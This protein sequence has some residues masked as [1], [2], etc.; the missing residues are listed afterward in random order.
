MNGRLSVKQGEEF[1]SKRLKAM[2]LATAALM[3]ISVPVHAE[4]ITTEQGVVYQTSEGIVTGL[5]KVGDFYYLFDNSGYMQTGVQVIRGKWYYFSLT[6]GR[7]LYGWIRQGS[8]TYYADPETGELYRARALGNHYFNADGT[9]RTYGSGDGELAGAAAGSWVTKGKKTYYYGASGTYLTGMQ[10]IDGNRYFF[11]PAGVLQK[12]KWVSWNGSKYYA[13]AN[14]AIK[15]NSWVKRKY[16][17]T[18][19]GERAKGLLNIGGQYYFFGLASGKLKTGKFKVAGK[20]Y[21]ASSKGVLYQNQLFKSDGEKYYAQ[22]DCTLASGLT[23]VGQNYYFFNRKNHKM[24]K[25]AKKKVNG[26]CYYFQKNGKA[27]R[28]KWVKIKGKYYYFQEDGTMAVNQTVDGYYVGSDGARLK[29]VQM[30][31]VNK[32]NGKYYLI[33]SNGKSYINTWVTVGDKVYYAG[34]DGAALTGLQTIDGYQYCFAEDGAMEKDTMVLI[35]QTVY[36]VNK[37]GR[38]TKISTDIGSAIAAY[39]QKFV[40]NPYVYGGTSLTNGADCS[41]FALALHA[42]FGIKL[43][44]VSDD[45]MHGPSAAYQR[46]GYKK[47]TVVRDNDLLPGDLIFYGSANYSSH[48]AVYIGNNKVVHA[49][50]TRMGIIITDIDWC[51]GRIHNKAMRYWA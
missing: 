28:D 6:T 17:V 38:V 31:G 20:V 16:Y 45:Q 29:K 13:A 3:L 9:E 37:S 2:L 24:V 49:A 15:T 39:G 48:T 8:R 41:G 50:N 7:M 43:L 22:D 47:G 42:H 23:R 51:P 25:N 12:K 35:G 26:R 19:S 11:N 33:D 30:S 34:S 10:T 27:A 40:G 44:R 18:D 32:I 4:F 1:M 36:T 46:Q 21:V 5:Q 14:G